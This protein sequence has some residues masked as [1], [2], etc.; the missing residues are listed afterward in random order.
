MSCWY[1]GRAVSMPRIWSTM[2]IK[3]LFLL[4]GKRIDGTFPH[5][6]INNLCSPV[7]SA[8]ENDTFNH[9]HRSFKKRIYLVL[10]HVKTCIFNALSRQQFI[11]L[12]C[13]YIED[14]NMWDC[15]ISKYGNA[16]L[17]D[18]SLC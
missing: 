18:Q 17:S 16:F 2:W 1:C 14:N 13:Y 12:F 15:K 11:K 5:E 9:S 6:I 8:P 3:V 4:S 7:S 10:C